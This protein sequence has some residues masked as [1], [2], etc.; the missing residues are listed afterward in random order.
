MVSP[1]AGSAGLSVHKVDPSGMP[2]LTLRMPVYVR[3][4]C[5]LTPK[6]S[7]LKDVH[8]DDVWV[9]QR[10]AVGAHRRAAACHVSKE[11]AQASRALKRSLRLVK[12]CLRRVCIATA[13]CCAIRKSR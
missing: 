7:Y 13:Q 4:T 1:V 12:P 9:V 3:S 11:A 5:C 2:V 10:L 6:P 8:T